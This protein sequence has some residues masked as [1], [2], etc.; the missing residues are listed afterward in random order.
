MKVA[1]ISHACAMSLSNKPK[2]NCYNR[3]RG[4]RNYCDAVR[5]MKIRI[6]DFVIP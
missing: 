1:L 3:Q 2:F 4:Q 6:R 5:I